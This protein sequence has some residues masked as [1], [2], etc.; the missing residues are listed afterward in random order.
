MYAL[1]SCLRGA[2]GS[3]TCQSGAA[4]PDSLAPLLATKRLASATVIMFALQ[5]SL[6]TRSPPPHTGVA[7]PFL[8]TLS[9]SLPVSKH[10][11]IL[12]TYEI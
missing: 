5:N 1:A 3:L 7:E 6:W 9:D 8:V 2:A 4:M 10:S 12:Y 11:I